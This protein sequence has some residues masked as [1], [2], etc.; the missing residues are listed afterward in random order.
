MIIFNIV[1]RQCAGKIIIADAKLLETED[2]RDVAIAS[3]SEPLCSTPI[4]GDQSDES[5][6]GLCFTR[7][8]TVSDVITLPIPHCMC[9]DTSL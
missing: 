7:S 6:L 1:Q 9:T 8:V 4:A 5:N 3:M 2:C